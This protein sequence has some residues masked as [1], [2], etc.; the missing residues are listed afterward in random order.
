MKLF[1]VIC[2][3]FFSLYNY[4]QDLKIKAESVKLNFNF[5]DES[6]KGSLSNLKAEIKFD[7]SN[8]SN[9]SISGTADVNTLSTGNK[10]R[11]KHLKSD[12]YFDLAKYPVIQFKSSSI[13][14]EGDSFKMKGNLTIKSIE[15]EVEFVFTYKENVFKGGTTI[16]AQDFGIWGK[17]KREKSKVI[18]SIEIPIL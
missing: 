9:S 6:T 8:L 7:V 10:M 5:V 2:S 18:I 13:T 17:G 14:K 4:S 15:K 16:Y 1:V 11:D 3:L 12:E